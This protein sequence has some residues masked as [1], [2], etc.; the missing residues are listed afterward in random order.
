M[1]SEIH[2]LFEC[3]ELQEVREQQG[4]LRFAEKNGGGLED[5]YGDYWRMRDIEDEERRKR[6]DRAVTVREEFWRRMGVEDISEL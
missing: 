4:F 1:L 3:K 6:V 5:Q 2:I